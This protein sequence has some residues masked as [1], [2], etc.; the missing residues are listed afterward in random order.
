MK[1]ACP[2]STKQGNRAPF[3]WLPIRLLVIC[4]CDHNSL[5]ERDP[6]NMNT[7]AEINTTVGAFSM[8]T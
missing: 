6:K 8:V 3:Q 4:N 7:V 5:M 2:C 1:F